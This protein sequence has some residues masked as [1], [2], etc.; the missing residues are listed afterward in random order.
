M[1]SRN[2][3]IASKNSLFNTKLL[4][5]RSISDVFQTKEEKLFGNKSFL[6]IIL[7][8]IKRT[9]SDVLTNIKSNKSN[10]TISNSRI[11]K[12]LKSL[13][14]DLV[15][16]NIEE[17][18]KVQLQ[19]NILEEKKKKI[20]EIVFNENPSNICALKSDEE[21]FES[22]KESVL[23][24]STKDDPRKEI[25]Q[26]KI[27]NFK[28]LNEITK[29]DNLYK[30]F[31]FEKEYYKVSHIPDEHR[32]ITIY[33]KQNENQMV[34][35]ILH[36]KLMTRRKIFIRKANMKNNQDICINCI[37]FKI[38]K[39]KKDM[40]DIY[41]YYNEQILSEEEKSY[42]ETIANDNKQNDNIDNIDNNI[43]NNDDDEISINDNNID[44]NKG[45]NKD[46]SDSIDKNSSNKDSSNN[47]ETCCNSVDKYRIDVK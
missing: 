29:V 43:N 37:K 38:S 24:E 20:K 44:I 30:R 33:I 47:E 21:N 17:L 16:I 12:I 26:L 42:L 2:K 7:G 14:K 22:N 39:F 15:Q 31:A 5:I 28:M 11:K 9:Q 25:S 10:E 8:I 18:K 35:K 46:E 1:A 13:K 36:N 3:Q 4:S 6:E 34:N 40:H 45:K 32:K 23:F 41:Q 19:E 27:L